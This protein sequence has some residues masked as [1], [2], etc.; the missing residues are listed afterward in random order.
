[1]SPELAIALVVALVGGPTAIWLGYRTMRRQRPRQAL[2]PRIEVAEPARNTQR[3]PDGARAQVEAEGFWV[4][5]RCRSLNLRAANRCYSCRAAKGVADP[6]VPQRPPIGRGVPVMAA[7]ARGGRSA[8]DVPVRG[9]LPVIADGRA[10]SPEGPSVDRRVPALSRDLDS[11]R[12]EPSRTT[13]AVAAPG[14]SHALVSATHSEAPSASAPVCPFIGWRDDPSTRYDFP[15][16]ANLC[17]ATAGRATA[18]ATPRGRVPAGSSGHER[19]QP[20]DPGYQVSSCLTALHVACARY[21]SGEVVA[22]HR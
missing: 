22:A 15:D 11:S 1:M 13:V 21:P 2:D 6:R 4:C 10:R 7:R 20:I 19:P 18:A 14:A 3:A 12:R 8:G 17:H 16:P 5:E 9:G